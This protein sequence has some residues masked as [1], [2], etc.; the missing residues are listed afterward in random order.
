MAKR[1]KKLTT[2]RKLE[3][4]RGLGVGKDYK[5][6]ITIQDFPSKGQVTRINRINA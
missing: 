3:E 6:W 1:S 4:G 2:E 5:P